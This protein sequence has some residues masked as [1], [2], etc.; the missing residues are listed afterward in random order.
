MQPLD[1]I[2]SRGPDYYEPK[3]PRLP[4]IN[5]MV[6]SSCQIAEVK[7]CR[8]QLVLAWMTSAR[9]TLLAM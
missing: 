5:I 2:V 7:Q 9:V 4:L 8:A 6:T 1:G 3:L